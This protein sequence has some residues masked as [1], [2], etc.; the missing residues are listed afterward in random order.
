MGEDFKISCN[1]NGI[2][3]LPK[4]FTH[5]QA[6]IKS[7]HIMAPEGTENSILDFIN[8]SECQLRYFSIECPY[9]YKDSTNLD[10][11]KFKKF[12]QKQSDSLEDLNVKL[13][14]EVIGKILEQFSQ[15]KKL[16]TLIIWT[17][18]DNAM[19]LDDQDELLEL[20]KRWIENSIENDLLE[21]LGKTD[22]SI[23]NYKWYKSDDIYRGKMNAK[24]ISNFMKKHSTSLKSLDLTKWLAEMEGEEIED[25]FKILPQM[26]KLE[27]I[28]VFALDLITPN[29]EDKFS[30]LAYFNKKDLHL[31]IDSNRGDV[32]DAKVVNN[33][34]E[35]VEI[36]QKIPLIASMNC[37]ITGIIKLDDN[38]PKS[39]STNKITSINNDLE[40]NHNNWIFEAEWNNLRSIYMY[41]KYDTKDIAVINNT[42]VSPPQIF[43]NFPALSSVTIDLYQIPFHY[44]SFQSL[45]FGSP[46]LRRLRITLKEMNSIIQEFDQEDFVNKLKNHKLNQLESILL[47]NPNH[48]IIPFDSLLNLLLASPVIKTL[49]AVLTPNEVCILR[50]KYELAIPKEEFTWNINNFTHFSSIIS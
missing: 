37:D 24:I 25:I 15:M 30:R 2:M 40:P 39:V 48:S 8:Q 32:R 27:S 13:S 49:D 44:R 35:L 17:D 16:K 12:L 22:C 26:E 1:Q 21:A 28:N 50:K 18:S 6:N 9:S 34:S 47:K 43:P 36:T 20:L 4:F 46:N 3:E 10:A 5:F 19:D 41:Q 31:T 29:E 38:H 11:K 42:T 33:M 23:E 45:L 7:L 14:I